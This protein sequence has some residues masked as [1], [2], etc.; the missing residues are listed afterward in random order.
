MLVKDIVICTA[1]WFCCPCQARLATNG[2]A[3]GVN[4]MVK[5]ILSVL[6][7]GSNLC[8]VVFL[9]SPCYEV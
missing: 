8:F 3:E 9:C 4:R 2:K 5:S 7:E 6:G 1:F